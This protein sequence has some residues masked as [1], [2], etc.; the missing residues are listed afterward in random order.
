MTYVEGIK[1]AGEEV[2][3]L[4]TTTDHLD[5]CIQQIY[6]N[7]EYAIQF[8]QQLKKL[9]LSLDSFEGKFFPAKI[10]R[11]QIFCSFSFFS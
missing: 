6:K 2:T 3:E 11:G 8:F 4:S 10:L 5:D 1:S 9:Q 7:P